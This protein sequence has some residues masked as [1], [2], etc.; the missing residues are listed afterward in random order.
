MALS[1]EKMLPAGMM[2]GKD[3]IE[4]YRVLY[5]DPSFTL[6]TTIESF[7]Y[8]TLSD[9]YIKAFCKRY[10]HYTGVNVDKDW[11]L[12][13]IDE[14]NALG[15]INYQM[16]LADLTAKEAR[17]RT[18]GSDKAYKALR[19]SFSTA[20]G[21]WVCKGYVRAELENTSDEDVKRQK[22]EKNHFVC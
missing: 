3:E 21:A 16:A 6:K 20:I 8:T 2:P 18:E 17:F 11:P 10:P 19:T 14:R 1:T 13:P 12:Q 7:D 9:T 22:T 4:K 15:C 5:Q